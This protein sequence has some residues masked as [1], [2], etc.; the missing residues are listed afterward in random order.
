MG[1][2]RYDSSVSDSMGTDCDIFASLS[3]TIEPGAT[4]S[5]LVTDGP[6]DVPVDASAAAL[7]TRGASCRPD[8]APGVSSGWNCAWLTSSVNC[9]GVSSDGCVVSWLL[10][11]DRR[12]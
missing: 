6:A 2:P 12:G 1:M 11:P 7:G 4:G 8:V 10:G 3:A 5:P 9:I